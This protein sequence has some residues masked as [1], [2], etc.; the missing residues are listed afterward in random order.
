M[1]RE[2][3]ILP[4]FEQQWKTLNLSDEDLRAVEWFLCKYPDS[5]DVITQT[6]GL[7][8]LRWGAEGRGK[9]GG[10]RI[11]YIDFPL[12][13]KTFFITVYP[14]NQKDDLNQEEKKIIRKLVSDLETE[15][16]RGWQK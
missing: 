8:K 12:Y 1:K 10:V 11:L 16:K 13:E 5:G 4:I 2:F 14:K 7:R 6:G 3:V 9:R 15:L